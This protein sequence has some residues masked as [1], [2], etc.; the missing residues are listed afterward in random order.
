[1]LHEDAERHITAA[2]TISVMDGGF[3]IPGE[4]THN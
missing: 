2:A 1:M 4:A 3:L